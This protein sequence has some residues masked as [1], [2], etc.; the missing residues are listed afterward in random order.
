MK[1]FYKY[2]FL[3]LPIFIHSQFRTYSNI[4]F[5]DCE[6]NS[7]QEQWGITLSVPGD[8]NYNKA[9]DNLQSTYY[10]NHSKQRFFNESLLEY[11]TLGKNKAYQK[12]SSSNFSIEEKDFLKLWL[13]YYTKNKDDYENYLLNF[14]TKYKNNLDF[15]K[16]ELRYELVE[17]PKILSRNS[18]KYLE[19]TQQIDSILLTKISNEDHLY[20]SLLKI[21]FTIFEGDLKKNNEKKIEFFKEIWK[22]SKD[23]MNYKSVKRILKDNESDDFQ[24]KSWVNEKEKENEKLTSAEKIYSLLDNQTKE[25]FKISTEVLENKITEIFDKETDRMQ[26][27]HI[28][29]LVVS[30]SIDDTPYYNSEKINFSEDFKKKYILNCTKETC[31]EKLKTLSIYFKKTLVGKNVINND[32]NEY[33]RFPLNE[34]QAGYATVINLNYKNRKKVLYFENDMFTYLDTK[35]MDF[36]TKTSAFIEY[37][38]DNPLYFEDRDLISN[39]SFEEI[40]T[41]EDLKKLNMEMDKLVLKFPGSIGIKSTQILFKKHFSYLVFKNELQSF[42]LDYFKN[43]IDFYALS[44]KNNFIRYVNW[45][46]DPFVEDKAYPFEN[47]N[48]KLTKDTRGKVIAY[49]QLKI[50]ENPHSK[51]LKEMSEKI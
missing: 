22:L 45:L 26:K 31:F 6:E 27:D 20:F 8:G 5:V 16:L 51:N 34:I 11:N 18:K 33:K 28:V 4:R 40:K 37:M 48:K 17:N 2:L 46:F 43:V 23:K 9:K 49:L 25:E 3:I 21:D 38:I 24:I 47:F 12:I 29:A 14:K 15:I 36:H 19:I 1:K 7:Y 10:N 44:Q 13:S 39:G 35:P 42:Y 30:C 50:S 32:Y 41:Y